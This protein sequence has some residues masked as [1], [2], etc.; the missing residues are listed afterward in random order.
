MAKYV[1]VVNLEV[2]E[3]L[4]EGETKKIYETVQLAGKTGL[5]LE[6]ETAEKALAVV[7]EKLK[8]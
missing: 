3:Q 6:A 7:L 4:A 8:A 5:V 1:A 2:V